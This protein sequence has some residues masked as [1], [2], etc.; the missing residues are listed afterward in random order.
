M[1]FQLLRISHA[2]VASPFNA[3]GGSSEHVMDWSKL[4]LV[5]RRVVIGLHMLEKI[6]LL[7]V[8]VMIIGIAEPFHPVVLCLMF[9][10][11]ISTVKEIIIKFAIRVSTDVGLEIFKDMFPRIE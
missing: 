9:V 3:A 4:A 6:S 1:A 8:F 11:F 5:K 7:I 10:P 2:K